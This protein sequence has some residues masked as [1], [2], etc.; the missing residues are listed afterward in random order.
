LRLFKADHGQSSGTAHPDG[1]NSLHVNSNDQNTA[2]VGNQVTSFRTPT[3]LAVDGRNPE[4]L[5]RAQ[6]PMTQ[7]AGVLTNLIAGFYEASADRSLWASQLFKLNNILCGDACWLMRHDPTTGQ[8][9]LDPSVN[10][11]SQYVDAYAQRFAENNPWFQNPDQLGVPGTVARGDELFTAERIVDSQFYREWLEPQRL[12]HS[13]VAVLDRDDDSIE[14]LVVARTQQ[15]PPF[16]E[17]EAALLRLLCPTLVQSVRAGRWFS[18]AQELHRA[19]CDALNALPIGVVIIGPEGKIEAANA[20]ARD[21][22]DSG[23]MISVRTPGRLVDRRARN[24]RLL[25]LVP[26]VAVVGTGATNGVRAFSVNRASGKRPLTLVYVPV[27]SESGLAG[28]PVGWGILFIA[29]PDRPMVIDQELL[30]RLYGLSPAEARVV[31]L[32]AKGYR[33]EEAAQSLGL[34]YETVRK[35]LRQVFAKTGTDRQAEL[36][37]L[38]VTGAA[39]LR[40]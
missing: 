9:C 37:R 31:V 36:V 32:L 39:G 30:R 26:Q 29:D 28:T 40:L 4:P 35:H 11:A 34:V 14:L 17:G 22:L 21:I 18:Q 12:Q 3:E 15:N 16:G 23:E 25:D 5:E 10:V 8:G 6:V 24:P 13:L 19:T 38:L 27:R 2:P 7:W 33:L 1:A 20:L